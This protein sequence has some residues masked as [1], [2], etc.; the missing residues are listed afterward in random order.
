MPKLWLCHIKEW[1]QKYKNARVDAKFLCRGCGQQHR[2]TDFY[3]MRFPKK[4]VFCAVSL[5][6][7]G[8]T[9]RS[10]KKS[11]LEIFGYVVSVQSVLN[12]CKRFVSQTNKTVI[13]GLA[14]LLH[15]DETKLKTYKKGVFLW[16]W[17]VKCPSTKKIVGWHVSET[18]HGKEARLLFW[19]CRR[20]F[21][22]TYWPKAIRT[23]GWPGYRRAIMEVFSH[24]VEH[25]KFLSFKEHSNNEIENFFRCKRRFP[26]FRNPESAKLYISQWISEYNEEKSKILEMFIIPLLDII[27]KNNKLYI[28]L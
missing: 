9:I 2:D 27:L 19:E 12:W 15:A 10:V 1:S 22:V 3:R 28:C 20:R 18:R 7:K 24:E 5:Y 25:D 21:P 17:A 14:P 23:D 16:L 8:L 11:I 4:I 26:R 13:D 6:H